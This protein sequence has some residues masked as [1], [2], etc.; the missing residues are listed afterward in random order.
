MNSEL[1]DL[2]LLVLLAVTRKTGLAAMISADRTATLHDQESNLAGRLAQ[3]LFPLPLVVPLRMV[4]ASSDL[5]VNSGFDQPTELVWLAA[6]LR[7]DTL[8]VLLLVLARR[9]DISGLRIWGV[10]GSNR[11]GIWE[12]IAARFL[13]DR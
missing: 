1:L 13:A 3:I 12:V 4:V 11:A 7:V 5:A 9:R 10:R 6:I 2:H 8:V